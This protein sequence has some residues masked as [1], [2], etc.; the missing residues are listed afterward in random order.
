MSPI[1][2][3]LL[4]PAGPRTES[5]RAT[6]LADS[7]RALDLVGDSFDSAWF[8]DHFQ[9][10]NNHDVLECWTTLS[11]LAAL[12]PALRFGPAVLGQSYRNPALT[13]KMAATLQYLSGGRLIFGIG[14]GWKEDEYLA[15]GYDFPP[16][17]VRVDQLDEALRIIKALW[18][19]ERATFHGRYYH[20]DQAGCEPKP[21]PLPTVMIGGEKPRMLRLVARHAD[22]WNVSWTG[23]AD[24]RDLVAELERACAEVGRDPATLRRTW[25]GGCAC[26]PTEERA[27]A[28][29]GG[30]IT[31]TSGFLG[32][33][34][35]VVEQM[36]SLV[37]L[38]IDYFIIGCGGFPDL[39]TL[40][41][42]TEQ[43]LP[44]LNVGR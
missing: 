36:Q 44:A 13:A 42:V 4:L 11:Y 20:V 32:T 29:G 34:E 19:E 14:A 12:Y 16:P 38:G 8:I 28:L 2:F 9:M 10:A 21:S 17:G 6:F 18:T 35:Q 22:W 39:T 23:P 27:A 43:V 1:Q 37:D 40:E 24:Y 7:R 30:R 3:G 33:P 15:Y 41:L 5:A 26:A 31:T 25:F